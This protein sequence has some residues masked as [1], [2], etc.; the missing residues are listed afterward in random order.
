MVITVITHG[1]VDQLEGIVNPRL[2]ETGKQQVA[3]LVR[4]HRMVVPNVVYLGTGRR[5]YDSYQAI[6]N[7]LGLKWLPNTIFWSPLLGSAD[8][9]RVTETGGTDV[10]LANGALA[11]NGHYV[12]L[13]DT[14]GVDLWTW[15][16]YLG[17][18]HMNANVLFVTDRKF[19]G[20]LINGAESASIY[21]INPNTRAIRK[22]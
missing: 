21:E 3:E 10:M 12:D 4:L 6:L 15:I 8:I 18:K 14:P 1:E 11:E 17:R 16:F 5:F 2:T 22:L 20:A 19:V 7:A 9:G 13:I